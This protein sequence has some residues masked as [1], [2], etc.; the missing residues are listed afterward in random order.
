MTIFKAHFSISSRTRSDRLGHTLVQA[1]GSMRTCIC[2]KFLL[3]FQVVGIFSV[4]K[5]LT[6]V[7]TLFFSS[8]L[9]L[10]A[11]FIMGG[12]CCCCCRVLQSVSNYTNCISCC[13]LYCSC[14]VNTNHSKFLC[15]ISRIL[16]RCLE[17]F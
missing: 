6:F 15:I 16:N 1:S 8:Y 10:G 12:S 11:F 9:I 7:V 2:F 14:A 17:C 13:L 5:N 4:L 3:L